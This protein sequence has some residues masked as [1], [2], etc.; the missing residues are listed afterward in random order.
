MAT[1]ITVLVGALIIE[2]V[3]TTTF[4]TKTVATKAG[5]AYFTG[6][7]RERRGDPDG[8]RVRG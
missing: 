8:S 2:P 7:Y 4:V 3:S 1:A 6:L 5:I